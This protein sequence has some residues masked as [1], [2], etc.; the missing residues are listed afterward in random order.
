VFFFV[1]FVF[2]VV[3][4][5]FSQGGR[6]ISEKQPFPEIISDLFFSGSATVPV[7]VRGVSRRTSGQRCVWRDAKHHARDA[8]API[9]PMHRMLNLVNT[10]QIICKHFKMNCLQKIRSNPVK[11][12]QSESN[13]FDEQPNGR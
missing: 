2:F 13:R 9:K 4:N 5:V 10:G 7:A 1:F 12:S 6:R 11:V 8:R 3:K